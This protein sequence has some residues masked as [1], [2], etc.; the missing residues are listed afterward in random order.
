MNNFNNESPF[1]PEKY[2][3]NKKRTQIII[4]TQNR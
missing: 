1:C 3:Y 4:A 2:D